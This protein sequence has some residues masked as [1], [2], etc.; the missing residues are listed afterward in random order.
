MQLPKVF[1]TS[2][3]LEKQCP[4]KKKKK[5]RSRVKVELYKFV[6]F[7]PKQGKNQTQH[8]PMLL[9]LFTR[10]LHATGIQEK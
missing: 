7:K 6:F 4:R 2:R 8:K 10:E 1:A 9:L 5:K 3:E